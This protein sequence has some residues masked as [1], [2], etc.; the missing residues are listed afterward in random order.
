MQTQKQSPVRE[1][2]FSAKGYIW[3]GIPGGFETEPN[4]KIINELLV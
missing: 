2:S 4:Q 3:Q 1:A